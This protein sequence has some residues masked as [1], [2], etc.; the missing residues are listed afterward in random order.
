LNITTF[1]AE[2]QIEIGTDFRKTT[3][4]EAGALC[5]QMIFPPHSLHLH[6]NSIADALFGSI[7]SRSAIK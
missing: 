4:A 1:G 5:L 2:S 3:A 6:A 7:S